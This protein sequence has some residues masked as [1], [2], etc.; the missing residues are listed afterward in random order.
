MGFLSTLGRVGIG[1]LA[2]YLATACTT[3][4]N[5]AVVNPDP[6]PAIEVPIE[7]EPVLPVTPPVP[8]AEPEVPI[9]ETPTVV[10]PPTV[11]PELPPEPERPGFNVTPQVFTVGFD[12]DSFPLRGFPIL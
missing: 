6:P 2:V 7:P 5:D 10:L 4:V 12:G 3:P 8:I 1:V 11:E 9:M